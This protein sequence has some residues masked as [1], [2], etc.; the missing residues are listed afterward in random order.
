MSPSFSYMSSRRFISWAILLG[1]RVKASLNSI[2]EKPNHYHLCGDLLI[3]YKRWQ[4]A[5]CP[6]PISVILGCSPAQISITWE[7]RVLNRHPVGGLM[8]LG[9]VPFSSL[10]SS[11]DSVLIS[12]IALNSALV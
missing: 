11:S 7:H 2:S 10:I 5:E 9:K 4:L 12:G 6:T 8:E 1:G 3:N